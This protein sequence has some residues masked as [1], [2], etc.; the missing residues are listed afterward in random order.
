MKFGKGDLVYS[1]SNYEDGGIYRVVIA[2]CSPNYF[3]AAH[4]GDRVYFF[5]L[6]DALTEG[7]PLWYIIKGRDELVGCSTN[8]VIHN[9]H[10]FVY[11]GVKLRNSFYT[12]YRDKKLGIRPI[13]LE[14]ERVCVNWSR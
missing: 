7:K 8:S 1:Y 14:S 13:V 2:N 11:E 4:A 3:V 12:S 6:K 10:G 9:W 5:H